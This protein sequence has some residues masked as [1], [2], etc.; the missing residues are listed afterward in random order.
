[1]CVL[2]RVR[3]PNALARAC[4]LGVAMQLTNIARDVGEDARAGRLLPAH[5][6][7]GGGGARS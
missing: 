1:M 7:A 5:R 3:D 2:M 6:L 4:D